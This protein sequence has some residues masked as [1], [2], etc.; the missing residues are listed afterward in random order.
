MTF[1]RCLLFLA[2]GFLGFA[3][4]RDRIATGFDD[5]Q[6]AKIRADLTFLASDAM[7]GRM[8]LDRGSEV[9][10][11]WIA[12]EFAKAGLKPLVGDTFLQPV[13]LVEYKMDRARTTLA[14]RAGGVTK[15]FKAPAL[16]VSYPND[17]VYKGQLVFAGFGI[18]APELKYD[19]YAGLDAKG[20]IVVIFNHEPQ[21]EDANSVFNGKGN[22]RYANARAKMTNALR[23]G[24]V[25][26]LVVPD[27]NHKPG[28]ERGTLDGDNQASLA[29]RTP[30]PIQSIDGETSI[31][32]LTLTAKLADELF[33]LTG[34]KAADLQTAIDSTLKPSPAS[35]KGAEVELHVATAQR[36]RGVSYNVAGLIEGSDPTLN[37]ETILYSAHYDH[38]GLRVDGEIYRGADDN[39]SG[40]VGIVSLARAFSK[41]PI[42]PKRS[43]ALVVFAA[44]E[45]GLLGAY[46]Y[47]DHPLRPLATTRA[48]VNFDMIGRDEK[49]SNQ[50]KGLIDIAADTSNEVNIIGTRYSPDYRNAVVR[51]NELVGIHLNYKWDDDT[52]L[53]VLFRSD[54]YPLLMHDIPAIWWFTGFHPDYHQIT[55]TAEKINYPKMEKILRLAYATGFDFGD[56]ATPPKFFPA[57]AAR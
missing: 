36:K 40:T 17:G 27:P 19:D 25:A 43:I 23:H 29:L 10:I 34:Q 7:E 21:E 18:T 1:A 3:Q 41:N 24:A 54:Q 11:Q 4:T 6:A 39:G 14:L 30:R 12:S 31:P 57:G 16:I 35:F 42:K 56:T 53:N 26:V 37:A 50:T 45:R 22:T 15:E 32:V 28:R 13:P 49:D 44:E 9:A 52:V 48:Q 55:D 5:I 20:K 51:A 8:S 46:Y 38:D 2:T 33:A 47:A